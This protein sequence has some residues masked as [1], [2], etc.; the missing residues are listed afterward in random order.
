MQLKNPFHDGELLVQHRVG[1]VDI[2]QRSGQMIANTLLKGA[3]TFIEQ[4]SMVILGS[5]DVRQDIWASMLFGLPGFIRPV[6]RKVIEIDLTQTLLNSNDPFWAN[7]QANEQIGMLMIEL[8]SR[9]RLRINGIISKIANARFRLDVLETYPNCPKYIQR[10][11]IFRNPNVTVAKPDFGSRFGNFIK[12]EHRHWITSSDTLFV[13][14]A[15]QERGVDASHRGG[16]PGFVQILDEQTLRIP[17]Y[18]GNSMFNTLGNLVI[19]PRAGIVFIDFAH[20]RTLQL[21]GHVV[22]H[23]HIDDSNDLIGGNHRNWD[24]VIEQWVETDVPQL[25][26]WEFLDFSP[27]N[28]RIIN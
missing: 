28:P 10:R 2:A 25:F 21:T 26:G 23:W 6:S 8:S 13:A 24:F 19:N 3:L 1:E 9:R 7:I 20:S 27:Y 4:Q 18:I 5:V 17:D 22:I 11:H 15:H 14:S 12:S 16:N